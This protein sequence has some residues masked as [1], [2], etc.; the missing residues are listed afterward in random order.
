MIRRPPRSTL[1]PYTTLFRSSGPVHTG[2][3]EISFCCRPGESEL[4]VNDW[5]EVEGDADT[6]SFA[7]VRCDGVVLPAWKHH[8]L[9]AGRGERDG[10]AGVVQFRN[11][12]TQVGSE[13]PRE[14]AAG[15]EELQ[16]AA[17]V[18]RRGNI[19]HVHIIDAG[20]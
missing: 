7:S 10:I 2:P 9:A 14:A 1:F 12:I 3:K 6:G 4:L 11:R 17:V 19:P 15:I 20:P 8:A 5:I 16:F 13:H 18:L